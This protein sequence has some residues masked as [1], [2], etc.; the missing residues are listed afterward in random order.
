MSAFDAWKDMNLEEVALK[1]SL[2]DLTILCRTGRL[3]MDKLEAV[4]IAASILLAV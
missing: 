1:I 4:K 2:P 3:F